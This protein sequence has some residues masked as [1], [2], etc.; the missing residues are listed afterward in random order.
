MA[1]TALDVIKGSLRLIH[2]LG[3]DT[4]LSNEEAN[5]ALLVLNQMLDSWSTEPNSLYVV[6]RETFTL[7]A[8]H[9]PHTWGTGGDF[10]SA[11][12]VSVVAAS[13]HV[14]SGTTVDIPL[15]SVSYDDYERIG[16]KGLVTNYPRQFY[17]DNNWPLANVWLYPVPSSAIGINFQSYKPL[18]NFATLTSTVS[19]PPGYIRAI[20]YNL[21]MELAPEYK[22]TPSPEVANI[23]NI[24]MQD[25]KRAGYKPTT[26][27][28]DSSLIALG[29]QGGGRYNPYSDNRG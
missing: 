9:N 20:R 29:Q 4:V 25:I 16:L 19:L 11:R 6:T 17:F 18:A 8:G 15:D 3:S 21:A 24:A 13:I 26:A 14:G 27:S 22:T 7:T 28:V 10:N 12:P 5:D 1:T 23:A 2:V